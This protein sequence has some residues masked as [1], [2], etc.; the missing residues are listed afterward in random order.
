MTDHPD[1]LQAKHLKRIARRVRG[2]ATKAAAEIGVKATVTIN[3]MTDRRSGYDGF[4]VVLTLADVELVLLVDE[5]TAGNDKTTFLAAAIRARIS[6]LLAQHD[7]F[8][9]RV[10]ALR[11]RVE[12]SIDRANA[13]MRLAGFSMAPLPIQCPFDW[14]RE[15]LEAAVETLDPMLRPEVSAIGGTNG[16]DF[17]GS[18]RLIA[19]SQRRRQRRKARL[20]AHHA[21]LE[22]DAL[23]E[24]AIA[25]SG[26]D[27]AAVIAD[28]Q[29]KYRQA[30]LYRDGDSGVDVTS[31][32][33]VLWEGRISLC[34][35]LATTSPTAL[36]HGSELR[37]DRALNDSD[38][39]H[40]VGLSAATL[41]DGE[42]LLGDAVIT[43][44]RARGDRYTDVR[45][46]MRR[47]FIQ[48][49]ELQAA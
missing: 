32:S 41:L 44:A 33:V 38:L 27:P 2:I 45:L 10:A 29:T 39:Q 16:R 1:D 28:L 5:V 36:I 42:P 15:E 24:A 6:E 40:V 49:D 43:S 21:M 19:P 34:A 7:R 14:R 11:A 48:V 9:E 8:A 20:D 22:I 3:P 30:D 37:L 13:G 47:R 25:R 17:A 23:A 4:R 26:R 46:G 12:A 35:R 31:V 18:M